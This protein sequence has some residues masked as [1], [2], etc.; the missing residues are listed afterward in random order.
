MTEL[1][2]LLGI[3]LLVAANGFFVAAEFSLVR[4][5]ESRIEQMRDEGQPP[6]PAGA[7]AD[8]PD[9]RVPVGL[10]ARH[11]D[12]LARHRLPGRARDRQPARGHLR[13]LDLPQR[14][15][16]DLADDRVP[17]HHG[18]AHHARRAGAQDLRDRP[19]RAHGAA[20]GSPA[21]VVQRR[22]QPAD[23]GAQHGLE[24]DPAP[25]RGRPARGVRGGLLR[26]RPQ[27]DHRPQHARRE[28]RPG[29]GG[30]ALGRL[31]P[32]RAGGAPGDDADPGGRHRR[33]V[34]QRRDRRCAARSTRATRA[35]S[36]PRTA[37]PTA[38]RASCT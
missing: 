21:A 15:P 16:G 9:R 22:P 23:L 29:R 1:L 27:A 26:R 28:A 17:G 36:S 30:H 24:R 14:L 10:P 25:G 6:R 4:A 2:F 31:P 18:A 7:G 35:W 5:R 19:R 32:A 8:R 38:S 3:L 13:R 33:R 20:R 34:G 11:H 12:G 37:T